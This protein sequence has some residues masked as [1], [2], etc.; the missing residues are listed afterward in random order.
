MRVRTAREMRD[1]YPN[2]MI[3][4][5]IKG[6]LPHTRLG[7]KMIKKLY[8]YDGPEHDQQAQKPQELIIK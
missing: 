5:S 8:I 4:R 1:N 6:M 7:R 2:E 3:Q